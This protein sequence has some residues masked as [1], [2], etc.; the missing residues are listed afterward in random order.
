MK[1]MYDNEFIR[2]NTNNI[3]LMFKEN[4]NAMLSKMNKF[5]IDYFLYFL[6]SYNLEYRK[7]LNISSDVTFGLEIELEHFKGTIYDFF[8]FEKDI[9][10]IVGN[11]EWDIKND[12]T[13][14]YGRE[15]A[16][17]IYTDTEK[18]WTDIENVCN[19]SEKKL[20]VGKR[21]AGHVNI[22]SHILGNN[23]LYWYRLLKLWGTYENVIYRFSYGEYLSYFPYMKDSSKP[24]GD[25]ILNRLDMYKDHIKDDAF[26]FV[27]DAFPRRSELGFLKKNGLSFYK[28][29]D[30]Y[31]YSKF[32]KDLVV[33]IRTPLSTLDYI[34]WQNYV[35]FFVRLMLYCKSDN[36]NEDI[37]DGRIY[38]VNDI[39]GDIDS[40][41][42]V[43]LEQA[44]ELSDMIFD[45][46]K[47]KIYFLK[48][49]LKGFEISSEKYKKAE[50]F[51][52]KRDL[53]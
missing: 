34:I 41:D 46:N 1:F 21:S 31:N 7:R 3:F 25:I 17:E 18:T 23:T 37:L 15:L 42:N 2:Y 30:E 26:R 36:F 9:N 20:E 29:F 4:D 50:K 53:Y 35:N 14:V 52:R 44:L 10:N 6:K 47:D 24:I 45:N 43:Y 39:I 22:G 32:K 12:I 51:T 49:Y 38:K 48:Q 33:E 27:L 16:T 19:F 5:D 40:Y 13:L 28:M 11:N 8:P